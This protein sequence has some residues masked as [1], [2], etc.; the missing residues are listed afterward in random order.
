MD[1]MLEARAYRQA[2]GLVDAARTPE[3][4]KA[5]P[6]TEFVQMAKRIEMELAQE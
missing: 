3:A 5:L 2:K 6:D 1:E 4:M